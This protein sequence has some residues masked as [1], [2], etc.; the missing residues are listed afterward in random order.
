MGI[1]IYLIRQ[2]IKVVV[3]TLS[4]MAWGFSCRYGVFLGTLVGIVLIYLN[5]RIFEFL[6]KKMI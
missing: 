2:C 3:V 6:N 1:I 5:I 4:I